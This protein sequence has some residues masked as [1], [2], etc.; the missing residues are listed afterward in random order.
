M[1]TPAQL[2]NIVQSLVAARLSGQTCAIDTAHPDLSLDDAYAIQAGVAQALVWFPDHRPTAW[3]VGG[4][5]VITAAPLPE[6]L[7]SPAQWSPANHD[8][9]LIEAELAFRLG[10]TP[11]RPEDA[12]A[13]LASVCVSIEVIGTRLANG[14]DAPAAWKLAD[15][16]VHAG[17]IIGPETPYAACAGFTMDDWRQQDCRVIVNGQLLKQGQGAH[18]GVN[19]LTTLPWLVDHAARHTGGLKAGDLITTGA[20]TVA[21][22]RRGDQ[23]E[24][25]FEGFGSA[26][27]SFCNR[28]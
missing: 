14:L 9:V 4:T 13:C 24:V 3:K 16:G 20:W 28:D 6:V 15:Q 8:E 27:L 2:Q 21:T 18:P 10:A 17:L 11:A 1:T 5:A 19:P 7:H 23:V 12:Q 22:I 26:R 25:A